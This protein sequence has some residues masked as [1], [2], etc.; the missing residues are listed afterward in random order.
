MTCRQDYGTFASFSIDFPPKN[1]H[2]ECYG[3]KKTTPVTTVP[4]L[5]GLL[6]IWAL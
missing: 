1:A 6:D 3:K 2:E 4:E 5:P